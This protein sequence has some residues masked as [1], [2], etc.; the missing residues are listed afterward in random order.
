[1]LT[2]PFLFNRSKAFR[3]STIKI[4]LSQITFISCQVIRRGSEKEKLL[5]LVRHRAG[6]HC[7]N[8]VIIIV[9]LAWEG[10]PRSLADKLY[11]ELSATIT[12]Y[13]NPTSR[14]CGLN[15]E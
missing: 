2:I 4:S 1:M 11:S 6:H 12:K 15:D 3:A 5:C 13:G 14:R 7:A 8:A 9:I 10:I